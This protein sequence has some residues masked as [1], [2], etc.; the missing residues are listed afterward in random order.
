[1][2]SAPVVDENISG[3]VAG[4]LHLGA[5]LW[6]L[7]GWGYSSFGGGRITYLSDKQGVPWPHS[8]YVFLAA[9]YVV[10]QVDN[11]PRS[12]LVTSVSTAQ[13]T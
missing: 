11:W 3:S 5:Y 7:K 8:H 1:M 10:G 4:E 2:V 12:T 6:G 13:A 9:H